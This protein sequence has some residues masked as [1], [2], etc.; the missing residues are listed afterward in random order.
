MNQSEKKLIRSGTLEGFILYYNAILASEGIQMQPHHV[1]IAKALIDKSINNLMILVGPGSGK[2]LDPETTV[3]MADRTWKRIKEIQVGDFVLLPDGQTSSDVV[4]VI[5]NDP[6]PMYEITFDDGRKI[7]A[8]GHHL[9]K[10]HNKKFS[11]KN[12]YW[13]LR[14]TEELFAYTEVKENSSWNHG[15]KWFIPLVDPIECPEADLPIHPYALGVFLGDAHISPNGD[16]N[17]TAFDSQIVQKLETLFPGRVTKRKGRNNT[18]GFRGIYQTIKD[19]KIAGCRS[20][21]KF[22]PDIYKKG[23][24]SQRLELIRGLFDTDGTVNKQK[25]ISFM[26]TSPFLCN[27]VK[28]ILQGL[29]GVVSVSEKKPFF[30]DSSGQRKEG[31]LAYQVNVRFKNGEN[32]FFLD[33]KRERA[34]DNQYSDTLKLGISKIE[35]IENSPSVCISIRDP[36]GLFIAENYIV[37]HN[38]KLISEIFPTY[39]LGLEPEHTFLGISG[40]EDLIH[41]FMQS[42]M[43]I[44]EH[45]PVYREIFPDVR[46]DKNAGWS[47]ER[48]LFVQGANL[49]SSNASYWGAGIG[50]KTLTGKHAQ[51]IIL[52]DIHNL[53][54]S[55]TPEQIAGVVKAFNL[56]IM[57]RAEPMGTRFIIAGR[58]WAVNDIYGQLQERGDFLTL[59]LPFERPSSK[60]LYFDLVL[61]KD[62]TTSFSSYTEGKVPFGI[63]PKGQGFFW[64]SSDQKRREYFILKMTAPR[65]TQATYQCRPISVNEPVFDEKDVCFYKAPEHLSMGRDYPEVSAFLQPFEHVLQ[66]WDT[67]AT[68]GAGAD[69]SCGL[70]AALLPCDRWHRG[71]DVGLVAPCDSHYDI[72]L[73]DESREKLDARKLI[74]LIRGAYRKWK[75]TLPVRIEKKSTGESLVSILPGIGIP[76]QAVTVPPLSKVTRATVSVGGGAFSVQGWFA[77]GRILLPENASWVPDFLTELI[78]FD[79][80]RGNKDD[81]VD[82]LVHLVSFVIE[83]GPGMS[84]VPDNLRTDSGKGVKL[85]QTSDSA[86]EN[87]PRPMLLP[88]GMGLYPE[89][90]L[91]F[92]EQDPGFLPFGETC[93]GCRHFRKTHFPSRCSRTNMVVSE[94]HFCD[95]YDPKQSSGRSSAFLDMTDPSLWDDEPLG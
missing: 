19:L 32:L 2:A 44:I 37:T 5:E 18:F 49:S 79:G 80:S 89:L 92:G 33:R 71:E 1:P 81:R 83:N 46:P 48:G 31:K 95:D 68:E 25:T 63:D 22:I 38:S 60:I 91:F 84:S 26:T 43:R 90:D 45:N 30:K 72:Y 67:A 69:W 12:L 56:N 10:V 61:P 27:D 62:S 57:G 54:N 70:T 8:N 28:E 55:S 40:G 88:H 58:R 3:L 50:S 94:L 74:P 13:R 66:T 77:L 65:E 36:E 87:V 86:Q 6:M 21:E 75:P 17:L 15:V 93:A 64:P 23:S 52:D 59:S 76:V 11:S 42:S 29:G 4:A 47:T 35:R 73:V 85:G 82:C 39:I 78:A 9:W 14:T 16:V 20:Y 24:I 41:G 7:K 51:T 34:K 53:E